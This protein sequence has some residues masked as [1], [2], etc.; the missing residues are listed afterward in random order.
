MGIFGGSQAGQPRYSGELH[1]LQVSESVFG[2]CAPLVFGTCRVHQKLLFYGGFFAVTA[3]NSGG[4]GIFGGKAT[5]WDYYA[6]M[7][8]LLAQGSSSEGCGGLINVWDQQGKLENLSNAYSYTIPGSSPT[9]IPSTNP[10]V[11]SDLGVYRETSYS[12]TATD[13]GAGG[14]RTLTGTQQI[15]LEKVSGSPGAGQYSFNSTTGAYTFSTANAGQNVTIC[16]SCVFSLYYFQQT[17]AAEIPGSPYQVS[18]NNQTYFWQDNGV[19]Y[20]DTGLPCTSYSESGGVYTFTSA[21]VG[22]YVYINYTYTSSSTDVTNSSTLN[23]TF[24][25]G[26]QGQSPWSYMT[27]KYPGADFGYSA[28]CYL[29]ANPLFLGQS[30]SLPSYNYELIGLVPFGGGIIDAH[31]CDALEVILTDTLCGVGFPAANIDTSWLRATAAATGPNAYAYWASNGYFISIC[32][33]TQQPAAD[34]LRQVIETGNV[35]AVWSDGLLKLIPY[36]DTTTVGNGYTYTPPTTPVVTLTWDNLLP[37]SDKRTGEST[38][39]DP[40][41]GTVRAPQDCMNYVQVQWTNRANS[42]NNELTPEQNDAFIKLYGFRPESPQTWDFITTQAAASW[43]LNLRLKRNCY[44]RNTYKFWL[45]FWFAALE[46]MDMVLLPTGEPVRI[47]QVEYD[48]NDRIAIEAEQW[49][50]GSADVTLYPKQTPTS[51]QPTQSLAIPGNTYP[52]IF[53]ATPQSLLAQPNTIQFAVAGNQAAWGGCNIFASPD[54]TTWTQIDQVKSQGRS[55]LLSAALPSHADPDTSNTLSV[56]MTISGGE[57]VSVTPAQENSFVT[58]AAIVDAD[59][60]LELISYETVAMTAQNRYN[61]TNLRRGVYGTTIKSHAIGAEFTYIGATGVFNYQYPAQYAG[62][63]MY[64]KFAS[65]N[66]TGNQVQDLSQCIEYPFL[67][68]GTSLQPP[69]T[70][71]FTTNPALPL[72]ASITGGTAAISCSAFSASLN[73]QDVSCTVAAS[74]TGLNQDQAYFIYYIDFSFEGG[75]I[76]IHATQNQTDFLNKVGYYQIL[77]PN[78]DGSITTPASVAGGVFRPTSFSD[79]GSLSTTAPAYAY[80]SNPTTTASLRAMNTSLYGQQNADCIFFGFSPT[81]IGTSLTLTVVAELFV[82]VASDVSTITVSIAGIPTVIFSLA[83]TTAK[84]SYT[85]TIPIGT[86][87]STIN[88]EAVVGAP[89][90]TS[91]G[92]HNSLNVYDINVQ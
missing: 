25:A 22:R 67:I 82:S 23:L 2:T 80:D 42:Y 47:T 46:P 1:N 87:L 56:D 84:A 16:Y 6:D 28:L 9:V 53:E 49:T 7:L 27:S 34:A 85:M 48:A 39:D 71:P 54:G 74:I 64:F 51:Y 88:V 92:A 60:S 15:S 89:T 21:D 66:T 31:P 45:P 73:N 4:K 20:V 38:S 18:T 68:P 61:I 37:P 12:V 10:A 35:A 50:Y 86:D 29:G 24:F 76:T 32:L 14:T 33:N 17:Q 62:E 83:T 36:G 75:A 43:A 13:Y 41:Q 79:N 8:M 91:G 26:K 72:L 44:I 65:F 63:T 30:A 81:L 69:S 55:G 3:P 77:G 70:G 19:T 5:E 52:V 90:A 59:G 40:L 11:G 78:P 58:L 57:L